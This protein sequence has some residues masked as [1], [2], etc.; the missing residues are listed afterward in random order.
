MR[1]VRSHWNEWTGHCFDKFGH[2]VAQNYLRVLIWNIDEEA[3]VVFSFCLIVNKFQTFFITWFVLENLLDI[4]LMFTFNIALHE[5]P[6]RKWFKVNRW[7]WEFSEEWKIKFKCLRKAW[8]AG[9][10]DIWYLLF[11]GLNVHGFAFATNSVRT[12]ISNLFPSA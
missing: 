1:R 11:L 4:S 6:F 2:S 3:S 10:Q 5:K 8:L 12:D 7:L 9:F